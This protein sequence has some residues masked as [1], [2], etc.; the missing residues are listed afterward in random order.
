VAALGQL[1]DAAEYASVIRYL[2]FMEHQSR[3]L[4]SQSRE[5]S[6]LQQQGAWAL[7]KLGEQLQQDVRRARMVP[8]ESVFEGFRK[9]IRDLARDEKKEI[10]FHVTGFDVEADRM[11][12]QSLKDPVMH[13]LRNAVDHGIEPPEE[14]KQQGKN[15]VGHVSLQIE[16]Q[17][18]RLQVTIEDDGRGIDWKQVA[19]VAERKGLMSGPSF[20]RELTRLL[21][22][23]G[24]STA[25]LITEL[26]GRGLGLSI[27]AE[28]VTRL[29]GEVSLPERESPGNAIVLTVPLSISTHRLLL[30]GCQNQTFA[31]PAHGIEHVDRIKLADA[32]NVE[33]KPMIRLRGKIL[34]LLSLAHLLGIGDAAVKV[35]GELVPVV[36]LRAGEKR[37]AIAVDAL[38]SQIDGLIKN[39]APQLA[40]VKKFVGCVLRGDGSVVLVLS[41]SELIEASR[42]IDAGPVLMTTKPEPE[43][44][45]SSILVVDD[46]IT[47]RTLEKSILEAHGYQVGVAVDGVEALN[48]LRSQPTDLVISDIQMPR[49]DGFGL[50]EEIK[51]D[52]RLTQLPV[53]LVTSRESRTDQE[54]GLALGADAYIVK[55][56][57]DQRNLLDTIRQIL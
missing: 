26:S 24:F 8:A 23:P 50:L 36:I 31:I 11:V 17:G 20:P 16:A 18:N 33:G 10:E 30:V 27:V 52:N 41:P 56:K 34:P 42:E 32:E 55:R 12:L 37:V 7:R 5:V 57:F 46:S 47:T 29:Q 2:N 15:P 13:L 4:A 51:K 38:L 45:P 19:A 3:A 54:R 44:K 22:Q 53:I 48:Y 25:K 43:A 40:R 6:R 14:R 1:S 28:A 35:E 39:I 9:M 49:L 21:F